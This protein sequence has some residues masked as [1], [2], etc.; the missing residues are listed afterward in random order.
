M[1]S[2]VS[3]HF[4]EQKKNVSVDIKNVFA[5]KKKNSAVHMNYTSEKKNINQYY[6][7]TVIPFVLRLLNLGTKAT[8]GLIF[9][10]QELSNVR[11]VV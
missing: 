6:L 9:V 5:S 4:L 1:F 11:S 3:R 2:Q 10:Y 7:F 8:P